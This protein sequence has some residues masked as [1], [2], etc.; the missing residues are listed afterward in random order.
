MPMSLLVL[1]ILVPLFHWLGD[2]VMQS[3]QMAEKK[4]SD[5]YVLLN[6]VMAYMLFGLGPIAV[7]ALGLG[8]IGPLG[9]VVFVLENILLHFTID[10]VTSRY[11]AKY[12]QTGK[13]KQFWTCVGFD[14]LLHQWSLGIT[15]ACCHYI[16]PFATNI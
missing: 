4:S 10:Y 6:H 15:L 9:V 1:L 14:Q 2:F 5:N 12:Y 11:S 16:Q 13:I 8:V 3:R 7:V